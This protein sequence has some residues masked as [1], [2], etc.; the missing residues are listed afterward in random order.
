[1]N[2]SRTKH[3]SFDET[4]KIHYVDSFCDCRNGRE[5]L[6]ASLDRKRYFRE[7]KQLLSDKLSLILIQKQEKQNVVQSV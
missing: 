6:L 2:V 7:K 3:V 5:W 1:M 4:V